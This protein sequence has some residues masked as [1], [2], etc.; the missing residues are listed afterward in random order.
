MAFVMRNKFQI[1]ALGL[2]VGAILTM[3]GGGPALMGLV[4]VALPIALVW[5]LFTNV[6]S[7]I[8]ARMP[9]LQDLMA[10]AE[11]QKAAASR[12][13][14]IDICPKCGNVERAGHRCKPS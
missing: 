8:L 1:L 9:S 6:K 3:R 5:F 4:K 14:T 10:A 13:N 7:R 11:Q 12:A 2:L